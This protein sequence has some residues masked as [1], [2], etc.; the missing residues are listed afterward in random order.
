MEIGQQGKQLHRCNLLAHP[1]MSVHQPVATLRTAVGSHC[2]TV[3]APPRIIFPNRLNNRDF[4]GE[5]M[6]GDWGE[7]RMVAVWFRGGC[8]NS[9]SLKRHRA[10]TAIRADNGAD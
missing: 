3:S 7:E 4:P 8:G 2:M 10:R 1:C 9:T 5:H 6:V